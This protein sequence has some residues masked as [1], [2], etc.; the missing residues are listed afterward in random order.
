MKLSCVTPNRNNAVLLSGLLVA[1]MAIGVILGSFIASLISQRYKQYRLLL[2]T[3]AGLSCVGFGC[4]TT[5]TPSSSNATISLILIVI[6]LGLGFSTTT[7][8]LFSIILPRELV[9]GG[10]S[11]ASGLATVFGGVLVSVLSSTMNT[12]AQNGFDTLRNNSLYLVGSLWDDCWLLILPT[13]SCA[14]YRTT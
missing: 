2:I 3:G 4:F 13:D 12:R 8:F 5:L 9:H 11:A 6:G 1:P 10:A 14:F 7:N